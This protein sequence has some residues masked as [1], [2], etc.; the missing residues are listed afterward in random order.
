MIAG[1]SVVGLHLIKSWTTALLSWTSFTLN[2]V[3]RNSHRR[4]AL[5]RM[6]RF[7][8]ICR[9]TGLHDL[10]GSNIAP[11][12]SLWKAQD[13]GLEQSKIEMG[14]AAADKNAAAFANKSR[15]PFRYD[16]GSARVN[17]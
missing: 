13:A 12:L 11:I 3:I 10:R 6:Q 2:F 14:S 9:L 8:A 17:L 1:L 5:S 15:S 16:P 7:K 4:S